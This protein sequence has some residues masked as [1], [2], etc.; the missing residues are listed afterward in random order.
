MLRSVSTPSPMMSHSILPAELNEPGH[1]RL[2]RGIALECMD[3]FEVEL[4]GVRAKGLDTAQA[5][6]A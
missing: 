4:H 5:R 1:E 6:I 2:D 3:P